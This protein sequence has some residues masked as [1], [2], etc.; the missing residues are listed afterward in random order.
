MQQLLREVEKKYMKRRIPDC[1]PGDTVRVMV[2]VTEGTGKDERTRLQAFEGVVIGLQ[3]GGID[4]AIRVRRVTHGIGIERLFPVHSPIIDDVQIVR[5]GK[6]RR[7][8]LYYLRNRVGRKARVREQV[9]DVVI[10]RE[11]IAR[12]R[13]AALAAAE[14]AAQAGSEPQRG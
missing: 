10:A 7:A 14:A 6:V 12:E 13:E 8:K 5:H 9:R 2:R 4:E 3:G 1:R 11:K